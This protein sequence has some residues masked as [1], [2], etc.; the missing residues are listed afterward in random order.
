M[1]LKFLVLRERVREFRARF[2]QDQR[3]SCRTAILFMLSILEV[4]LKELGEEE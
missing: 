4:T 3:M 2:Q 1:R